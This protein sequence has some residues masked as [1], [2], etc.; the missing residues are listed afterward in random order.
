MPNPLI[1]SCNQYVVLEPGEKEK[2]LS[3]DETFEWLKTWLEKIDT[4]PKDLA[5]KKSLGIAAQHLI[6]TACDLEIKPGFS[7][8]WFAVRL[9]PYEGSE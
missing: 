9:S 7:I 8:S 2:F 3:A 5:S 4:L 1:H 6:D